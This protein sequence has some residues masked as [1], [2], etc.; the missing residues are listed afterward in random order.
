MR[1]LAESEE[2]HALALQGANDG[3]WDWDVRADRPVPRR[4]GRRC[5]ATRRPRSADA[6]GEWLGRVHP[7]DRA[8]LSQALDASS[9]ARAAHFEHEYRMEHR[10]GGYRWMLA[11]G[12][13][14]RDRLARDPH[15]RQLHRRHRARGASSAS[16]NDALHDD[17]HRPAE[18]GPVPRPPRP[19]DPPRAAQGLATRAPRCCSSTSTASRSSTTRSATSSATSCWSPSRGAW[20]AR[21]R[22]TDTVARIGGDEF[23]LLLDDVTDAREATVVADRVHQALRAVRARRPRAVHRRQHRHRAARTGDAAPEDM[24]RDA[25]IA[26][27]R[28]KADGRPPRGV[29]R[30]DA[31]SRCCAGSTWR[32]SCAARSRGARSRSPTSPSCRRPTGRIAGFEALCSLADGAASRPTSCRWPRRRA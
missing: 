18:P 30:G 2:R 4:A 26:M 23:T 3:L 21:L 32:A 17:A 14:V 31:R 9:R 5:S 13:A 6:P 12:I 10:D 25:D 24:L 22:P 8:S 1:A 20:R 16:Q 29:R 28:A 15:R 11:R 7:D 19:G 27:Y